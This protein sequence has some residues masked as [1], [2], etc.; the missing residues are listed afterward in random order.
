MILYTPDTDPVSYTHLQG[1]VIDR[2]MTEHLLIDPSI[3]EFWDYEQADWMAQVVPVKKVVAEGLYG[4]RLDRATVY[5]PADS[6]A[7]SDSGRL[8][9]GIPEQA[10]DDAQICVLEIWDKQTQRVYTMAQGC[11]FWLRAPYSPPR[12]VYKRQ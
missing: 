6:R 2:V 1:L 8:F 12:D 5:R 3:A 11:D 4:I 7:P 9:S 10:G